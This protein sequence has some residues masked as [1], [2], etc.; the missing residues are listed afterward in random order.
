MNQVETF[1]GDGTESADLGPLTEQRVA[2]TVHNYVRYLYEK[3]TAAVEIKVAIGFDGRKNSRDFASLAAEILARNGVTV[4]L[5]SGVVPTPALS[6]AVRL[7]QCT[8]GIMITGGSKSADRNGFEFRTSSGGRLAR[9]EHS[10]LQ[11]TSSGAGRHLPNLPL[12]APAIVSIVD[13]LPGYVSHLETIIDIPKLTS[14]AQ[15]AKNTANV[16]IDSMGGA[17]QTVI[18]DILV[19]AG[20]RAQTLFSVPEERFFDRKPEPQPGNL[21]AL[22]YNVRVIDAQMGIATNGD[23]SSCGIIL[24]NGDWLDPQDLILSLLRHLKL[25]KG[26]TGSFL[27]PAY[28]TD[29]ATLACDLWDIPRVDTFFGFAEGDRKA[30]KWMFGVDGMGQHCFG[31]STPDC[32]GILTGLLV[33]EMVAMEGPYLSDMVREMH[34]A[35]GDSSYGSA[36]LPMTMTNFNSV[37]PSI[38]TAPPMS[39]AKWPS[40]QIRAFEHAGVVKGF[41]LSW[42]QS[43]WLLGQI[44]PFEGTIQ[45]R[46]EAKSSAELGLLLSAGKRIFRSAK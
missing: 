24:G 4:L 34:E 2:S 38:R 10:R 42:G 6:L 13:F 14:F 19:G 44:Q 45:L 16:L 25:R 18:E 22:M 27:M 1:S 9:T 30:G 5:S 20:W 33:A 15:D 23:G 29:R 39:D 17:G 43:R 28:V 7:G 11:S 35:V 31:K 37:L 21:H 26:W 8:S 12:K 32:D 36:D 46:A 41:K 40:P 3:S